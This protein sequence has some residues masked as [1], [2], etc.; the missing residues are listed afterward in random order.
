VA[1]RN[2]TRIARSARQAQFPFI[3]TIEDLDF[4]FQSTLKRQKLGPYL[5]PEL[6]SEGRNII[7]SGP[8]G[9]GKTHLAVAIGYRAIQ[10]GFSAR[11]VTASALIDELGEASR[12]GRLRD[13]TAAWIE[14]HVLIIDEVGYLN[15]TAD[16][17]NLLFSVVD[18]RYLAKKPMV[19]TT[20]K[21]LRECGKVLHDN[22]LAEVI[23]DRV[24][25]RG[26]LVALGGRSY[27]DAPP[28]SGNAH[29]HHQRRCG[30]RP[31]Y[32]G[33]P[34]PRVTMAVRPARPV[35]GSWRTASKPPQRAT[36]TRLRRRGSCPTAPTRSRLPASAACCSVQRAA[37]LSGRF[38]PD[39]PDS[40]SGVCDGYDARIGDIDAPP[41]QSLRRPGECKVRARSTAETTC[42]DAPRSVFRPGSASYVLA[43][44]RSASALLRDPDRNPCS[45]PNQRKWFPL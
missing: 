6:V 18:R 34:R 11:F 13:A 14:P 27:P 3:K 10:N 31:E 29:Q 30:K 43:G 7:L 38:P 16:A 35:R 2:D 19:F 9:R 33:R 20:N 45:D 25:E 5:G 32:R 42:V 12:A 39:F 8:P 24:L 15:H 40:T 4:L 23:L 17:A 21:K 36:K 28:R 44:S 41:R 22:D 1:H 37:Q 26:Q